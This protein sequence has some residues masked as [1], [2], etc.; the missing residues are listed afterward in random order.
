MPEPEDYCH[1]HLQDLLQ[2]ACFERAA[3]LRA[4]LVYLWENKDRE[5]SEYAIAVE[6]LHRNEDFESKVD[7]TV[8]VQIWRLRRMLA[9]Y[10]QTE[11]ADSTIRLT[12][13]LGTHKLHVLEGQ[14]GATKSLDD[15]TE[16]A[17]PHTT[18]E[19]PPPDA[20]AAVGWRNTTRILYSIVALI[21][22][23]L[24]TFLATLFHGNL[25]AVAANRKELPSFWKSFTDNGKAVRIVV[26]TPLF[27]AW[28][29]N[30]KNH[31]LVARDISVNDQDEVNQSESLKDLERRL[32]KPQSWQHYTAASDTFASVQLARFLDEF[33]IDSSMSVS[34][35]PSE[36]ISSN[37]DVITMGSEVSL[38]AYRSEIGQLTYRLGPGGAYVTDSSD[39]SQN[40]EYR[41][42]RE[43][44]SRVVV[45]GIIAVL[46]QS[47]SNSR[48]LIV[49]SVQTA[50]LISFITSDEGL[51]ELAKAISAHHTRYFEA[52]VLS[53]VGDDNTFQ[54]RL[55]ALKPI[56]AVR[57]SAKN[58]S[59]TP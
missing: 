35:E 37:E 57:E 56:S 13:P 52:V 44:P 55:A 26:P 31:F 7:A 12:I 9:R 22:I 5:I 50:A 42:V 21:V 25:R 43:S 45:P 20:L 3:V 54:N 14:L 49:E 10:Y 19:M 29:P 58:E 18:N 6:A 8:R 59:V 40:V 36:A 27:F 4:L 32:G 39:P 15:P 30:G 17:S 11:G 16:D 23:C 46:P 28:S 33:G 51:A 41:M 48:I 1:Q 2:S 24:A 38:A 53:E 34:E 47:N